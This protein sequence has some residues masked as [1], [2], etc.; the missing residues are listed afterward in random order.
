MYVQL[1]SSSVIAYSFFISCSF[2]L[3]CTFWPTQFFFSLC[4]FS[5]FE[6][7]LC[8]A[9]SGTSIH[10]HMYTT[11]RYMMNHLRSTNA[12]FFAS[13]FSQ[14]AS[15]IHSFTNESISLLELRLCKNKFVRLLHTE[16]RLW[17]KWKHTNDYFERVYR[18]VMWMWN[19]PY[20]IKR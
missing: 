14:L 7:F 1:F 16:Q 19:L 10:T 17:K 2:N 20:V 13:F 5:T 15:R 6:P 3:S 8:G 18:C 9:C 12:A 4:R 11:R